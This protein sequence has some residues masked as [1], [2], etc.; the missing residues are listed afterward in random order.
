MESVASDPEMSDYYSSIKEAYQGLINDLACK[1][2][3]Y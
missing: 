2:I 1:G 3:L